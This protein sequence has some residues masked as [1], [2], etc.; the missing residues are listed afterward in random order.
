MTNHFNKKEVLHR[1]LLQEKVVSKGSILTRGAREQDANAI[2]KT[3]LD[4]FI[5]IHANRTLYVLR[6][7]YRA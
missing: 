2:L 3:P 7:H 6:A 5:D 4:P 1:G